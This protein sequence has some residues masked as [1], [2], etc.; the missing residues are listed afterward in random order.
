MGHQSKD[1][2]KPK[3]FQKKHAQA[4]IT[5]VDEVSDGVA[6]IDI[7]AVVLE[8]NMMGNSKEWWVDTGA[9]CH[10]CANKNLFTS[11]VSVANGEQLFMG[12]SSMSKV[13]GQGKVILKMTSENELTLNNVLHVP[14]IRKNLIFGSLLSKNGFQLVF[15]SDKF[16]LSKNEMY[17]GKGYLSDAGALRSSASTLQG[18]RH[19]FPCYL[20]EGLLRLQQ[21]FMC[22]PRGPS[23]SP[24]SVSKDFLD[25]SVFL[26]V[27]VDR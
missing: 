16:V 12:N 7:C 21:E 8:C 4:H 19:V 6:D 15:V 24:Y 25:F 18:L 1:C 3:N 23:T 13:E 10:I 17:I 5:E 27:Q 20:H 9:T 26:Q 14:D 2:R 22:L 11:Y